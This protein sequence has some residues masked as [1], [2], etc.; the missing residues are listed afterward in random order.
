MSRRTAALPLENE[1]SRRSTAVRRDPS[2]LFETESGLYLEP[3]TAD[4]LMD[5]IRERLPSLVSGPT[6][7]GKT[8]ALVDIAKAEG[9]EPVVFHMAGVHDPEAMFYGV[10]QLDGGNTSFV[11]SLFAKTC[12]AENQVL[13]LDEIN[14]ASSAVQNTCLSL[15][16]W[17]GEMALDVGAGRTA[18][19]KIRVHPSNTIVATANVGSAYCH[20]GPIDPA[21]AGRCHVIRMSYPK[22]ERPLLEGLP[23]TAADRILKITRK[24]RREYAKG[25]LDATLTSRALVK[26]RDLV[27]R[28]KS[29]DLAVETCVPVFEDE[30][31]TALRTLLRAT[32]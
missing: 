6:G 20:A 13:I 17:Q 31:L 30:G 27:A 1:P 15:M 14:R 18:E 21:F 8:A 7:C 11:L 16:D 5:S 24:V 25:T 28:G 12:Q 22:D 3:V 4:L 32:P 10:T 26:I 19:R 23:R 9:R 29:I 2:P